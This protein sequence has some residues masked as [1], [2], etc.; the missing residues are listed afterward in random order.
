MH[1]GRGEMTAIR[2]YTFDAA[3]TLFRVYPSV[4]TVYADVAREFG[5][6][7]DPRKIDMGFY[8][9]WSDLKPEIPRT[10]EIAERAWW[11]GVVARTFELTGALL[12]SEKSFDTLFDTLFARFEE[13]GVWRV[14]DE[15]FPTLA[16]LR[17][18]GYPLAIISNFDSRLHTILANLGLA[19]NFDAV[20]ISA[21]A[22][23]RKPD[24]AIFHKACAELGVDPAETCHIGDN[25]EE[26]YE[27]ALAAGMQARLLTRQG[28]VGEHCIASLDSL[29][30]GGGKNGGKN[31]GRGSLIN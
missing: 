19:H 25:I 10:S 30:L 16:R 22:G 31:S 18:E 2:A 4:G 11:H 12:A 13:N 21:A 5:I 3:M 27:G 23:V 24:P 8:Q 9:A 6:D 20:V 14:Y 17:K 1:A 29:P 26:D 28:P 15:V 7:A